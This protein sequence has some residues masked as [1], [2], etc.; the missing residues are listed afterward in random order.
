MERY[1]IS[2]DQAFAVIRR[3]SSAHD[4]KLRLIA[5]R[6]IGSRSAQDLDLAGGF[7]HEH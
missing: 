1:H 4:Q 3:S 2:A 7:E 6:I 5:E